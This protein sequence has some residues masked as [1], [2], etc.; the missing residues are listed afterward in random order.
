MTEDQGVVLDFNQGFALDL[1]ALED[2]GSFNSVQRLLEPSLYSCL[3]IVHDIFIRERTEVT[4]PLNFVLGPFLGYILGRFVTQ[5]KGLFLSS[6]KS[7]LVTAT[8]ITLSTLI[9]SKFNP[10]FNILDVLQILKGLQENDTVKFCMYMLENP[11]EVN[12]FLRIE[13]STK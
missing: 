11:D 4:I 7:R 10:R 13:T 6:Q 8:L 9:L 1:T 12:K 5:E 3:D 2:I